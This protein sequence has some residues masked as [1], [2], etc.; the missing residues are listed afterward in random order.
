VDVAPR[1]RIV[2]EALRAGVVVNLDYQDADG[3]VTRSRPVEPLAFA[4]TGGQWYL[5]GWCHHAGA[6]RWFRLDRILEA[7]L[8]RKR[9]APRDLH[10]TFG[11]PPQDARP[12]EMPS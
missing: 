7:R 8:T 3:Q 10:E 11:V 2:D 9:S 1:P 5:L 6:G 12:V 4:R